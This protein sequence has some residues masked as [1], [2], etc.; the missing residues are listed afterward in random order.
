MAGAM[1]QQ[2]KEDGW[3]CML[4]RAACI[5]GKCKFVICFEND[6]TD[7]Y[8]TE[9]SVLGHL[10]GAIPI[11]FGCSQ[12]RDLWSTDS[13]IFVSSSG[14]QPGAVHA[15]AKRAWGDMKRFLAKPA[16]YHKERTQRSPVAKDVFEWYTVPPSKSA[17]KKLEDWMRKQ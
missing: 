16:K 6:T 11:I 4:D 15:A 8:I 9:K 17:V 5:Y 2:L 12:L 14:S 10:A 7:Y 1:E 3:S 13:S